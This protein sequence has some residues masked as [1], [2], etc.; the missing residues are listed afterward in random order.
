MSTTSTD[1]Q[2]PEIERGTYEI[3]RDRLLGHGKTL[4]ERADGLNK[5]RLEIFGGTELAVLGNE[6]IRTENN[7]VPRDIKEVGNYLLFGYNV[8]IGLKKETHVEDVLSLHS[9]EKTEDGFV[10]RKVE[11][12]SPDYFLS[13]AKFLEEFHELYHYYKNAKL[14]QLRRVGEKLLAV[15][16]IGEKIEDVR[17]FR[18]AVSP[19]GAVTYIDNRGERDHVFPPTHDFEWT[20]TAREEHVQGRHPHVNILDEVFVET[21]GGDLTIK[22]ENNTEDG[23]GIYREPVLDADQSLDDAEVHYAKVGT[24]ILLKMLPYRETEYRYLVYNTRTQKVDRIDA[25]GQSC[26]Q[27]PEDHGLIFPGG[28]YLQSGHTKSFDREFRGMEFMRRLRSPNGEDVLYAFHERESGRTILLPYNMIRKEVD[29]PLTCHGFSLYPDGTLVV[30]RADDDDPKRVH[31]MQIWRTPFLSD[32]AVQSRPPTGSFLEKVGNA[33]LVRGVSDCLSIRRMVDEQEP[34]RQKYEDLVAAAARVI[35]SYYWLDNP[36]IGNLREPLREV[37]EAAESIIDEFEK[38]EALRAQARKSLEKAFEKVQEIFRTIYPDS[39]IS[40]DQYV[41]CLASLRSARGQ[42][43]T[44]RETRYIDLAQIDTI[45]TEI[46]GRFDNVSERAVE[47]LLQDEALLPYQERAREL[48]DGVA[49]LSKVTEADAQQDALQELS[50]SLDLLTDVIGSLEIDDATIRTQILGNISEIMGSLNRV[51]ALITN[52]RKELLG[53]EGVAEFGVQ[54]QLLSQ[55]VTSALSLSD[56][57]EKCD[58]GLSKLMLQLEDL[59]TRFSEFEEFTDELTTKREEVYEAFSSKKQSLVDRRQRRAQN[60]MQAAERILGSV[61]RRAETFETADDLNAYFAADAMVAKLRSTANNLREL[62]DSV[63]ADEIDGRLKAAKEDAARGLRDRQEIYEDGANVIKLG[64]HRFSVNT[65]PLELTM[66][67]RDDAMAFHLT[68]TGFYEQV[69]DEAFA[70]TRDFWSQEL[71]SET[72]SVYRGEYLAFCVL[73]D[74][75]L[76]D[77]GLSL[78]KLL[79]A[80]RGEG[81]LSSIVRDF[82]AERYDEGYER[83]V[84]DADATLILQKILG[85]HE[86]ADL[87]RFTPDARA[88]AT[89][90]WA[91]YSD[92]K[93]RAAWESQARGLIRLRT[94]FEHSDAMTELGTELNEAIATHL[95]EIGIDV[96][97]QASRLAGAY[98]LEEIAREPQKFVLSAD[99]DDLK[100]AFEKHLRESGHDRELEEDLRALRDTPVRAYELTDAWM[101]AFL[102]TSENGD[103][104]ARSSMEAVVALL[105]EDK[106]SRDTSSAQAKVKVEGL[107]GQHARMPQGRMELHL[108]E[109]LSR[110]GHFR[111]REVP[112]FRD[113]QK[114]RH[115]VLERERDSL[116]LD[117]YKAKVMSSFVRNRLINDVYLPLIGDNLAKQMGAL[118]DAKRTDLMGMLLLV[119]PPG[120]GK[121]TLMEYLANRLGLVFMKINGPALGHS[122]TSLDPDEAPNATARQEVN[123]L[124]LA[125]EMGNNVLLY[126]DDIQHTHPEFLQKFISLCD[127]QRKVEGVWKGRTRT[128]D[129]RGKKF[130]VC[131]AGNPYTESGEKFRIPDMLANRADTYNLGDILEGKDDFFALSYIENALTSNAVLAP[132]TT[133]EQS[134]IELLVRMANGEAIQADQLKHGYSAVEIGEIQSVLKKLLQ[135]QQVLLAINQQYIRSASQEDAYRTEPPFRLQGS[136]RNMNKLAEKIVAAMNDN[137]LESLIDDHYLGES[138]TLTTGAEENLLKLAEMRGRMSETQ[139]ARWEEIKSG[140]VRVQRMGSGDDDPVTRVTGQLSL[141]SEHLEDIGQS[142]ERAASKSMAASRPHAPSADP[143]LAAFTAPDIPPNLPPNLEV[144]LDL[145]PYID[146]LHEL[147]EAFQNGQAQLAAAPRPGGEAQAP[148]SDYELISRESYLI[149]G[150]LIP[151]MRFMAHRF[152][153]YRGVDDPKIKALIQRLEYV[154]D[155]QELVDALEKINVSALSNITEEESDEAST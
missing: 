9:H 124:N 30:F 58:E 105:F 36:E 155:L 127:A 89:V 28:Y 148:P 38:V 51:R 101:A 125:F 131:M 2:Q 23:Q 42:L 54:F 95:A 140:F 19:D 129:L 113:F 68:G 128:Y 86:T 104:W 88:L 18:W 82:A 102:A 77:S 116:R 94:H 13:D 73:E 56:T 132:L 83:S 123:K 133:R 153:G 37:H 75:E 41:A 117:E 53:K 27:L 146:K 111:H 98:L 64:R 121:T 34:T 147:L 81:A 108:D 154:D 5:K 120:Y 33:E 44:L 84:H 12:D 43:I 109:F 67:P 52:R 144:K 100:R 47:F 14:L 103:L 118:G 15:F 39:W 20:L 46:V 25:I 126:V 139:K 136:Y 17:V 63:H 80:T 78:K 31:G 3:I 87:L 29:N 49:A 1:V 62:G 70:K 6:R 59:E 60:L 90:F 61:T 57:P 16:Q 97:K 74:A 24:L 119:S 96:P 22:V 40:I 21:V 71:V 143:D 69:D 65:Q 66:V 115:D 107:L 91:L 76:G 48:E 114:A 106:V 35:D 8:F 138:Q 99:A 135:V 142:I 85:M 45:E 150:T 145:A 79:E 152:R 112:G 55:S 32:E 92:R 122:V 7:C 149:E 93:K 4:A 72:R 11:K 141:V 137:E 10:F 134:D 151:L 50:D 110:L 26:V 130:V